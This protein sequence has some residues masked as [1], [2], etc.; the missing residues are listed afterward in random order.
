MGYDEQRQIGVQVAILEELKK[1][2]KVPSLYDVR[3]SDKLNRMMVSSCGD[4]E[5]VELSQ[6]HRN[7]SRGDGWQSEREIT[8]DGLDDVRDLHYLLGKVLDR[9]RTK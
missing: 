1:G 2:K 4:T 8:L 7:G 5:H 6:A 3:F 9:A